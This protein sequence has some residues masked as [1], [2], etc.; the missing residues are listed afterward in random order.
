ME[1]LLRALALVGRAAV[2]AAAGGLC[3]LAAAAIILALNHGVAEGG[4]LLVILV[5]GP[6]ALAGAAIALVW[7]KRD[8]GTR[9]KGIALGGAAGVALGVA[10]AKN[11]GM[12]KGGS[13]FRIGLVTVPLGFVVGGVIGWL[14]SWRAE[15]KDT[16]PNPEGPASPRG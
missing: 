13:A 4:S 14:C 6:G 16:V 11:F 7:G 1:V 2:G 12:D 8:L 5:A 3:A 10:I 15:R 9:A